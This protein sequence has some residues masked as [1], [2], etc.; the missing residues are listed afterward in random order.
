[1]TTTIIIAILFVFE[2]SNCCKSLNVEAI[3]NWLREIE[4]YT[5]M[6]YL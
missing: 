1:M 5:C 4:W 2:Y 3:K 6:L